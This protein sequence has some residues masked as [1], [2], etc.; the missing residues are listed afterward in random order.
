[1]MRSRAHPL[2]QAWITATKAAA[3]ARTR[4]CL[5]SQAHH[6]GHHRRPPVSQQGIHKSIRNVHHL[7]L[8]TLAQVQRMAGKSQNRGRL[9]RSDWCSAVVATAASGRTG[10]QS[11]SQFAASP[12]KVTGMSLSRVRSGA[13]LLEA[14]GGYW[15]RRLARPVCRRP[16]TLQHHQ[17]SRLPKHQ[18]AQVF[19]P[20][21]RQQRSVPPWTGLA[22][23]EGHSPRLH[24]HRRAHAVRRRSPG[25]NQRRKP[26]VQPSGGNH[27][28]CGRLLPQ[29]QQVPPRQGDEDHRWVIVRQERPVTRLRGARNRNLDPLHEHQVVHTHLQF[30]PP[31][32]R[33]RVLLPAHPSHRREPCQGPV[34][35]DP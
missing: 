14:I 2:G 13:G 6:L 5:A 12:L 9:V 28:T 27:R 18:A 11:M 10:L 1:M 8:L 29:T 17:H 4:N 32:G 22:A 30:L 26:Q 25:G 19:W 24:G 20:R 16:R 33:D 34:E 23:V 3:L 7:G 15:K 21:Q 35:T 31:Q